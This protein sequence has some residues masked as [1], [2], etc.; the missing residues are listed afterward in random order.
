MAL[1]VGTGAREKDVA[2]ACWRDIYFGR[3]TFKVQEKPEYNYKPKDFEQRLVPLLDGL[4]EMLRRRREACPRDTLISVGLG[5]QFF[6]CRSAAFSV[7]N[8]C[9]TASR[10]GEG[11]TE[12]TI[13]LMPETHGIP[14]PQVLEGATAATTDLGPIWILEEVA[15]HLRS[16]RKTNEAPRIRLY[17]H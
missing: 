17:R 3:Q 9:P 4:T 10:E 15:G 2:T 12:S 7:L 14:P 13:E 16:N 5:K 8:V 1:F 6:S 11:M